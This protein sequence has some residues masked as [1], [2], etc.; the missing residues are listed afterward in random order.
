MKALKGGRSGTGMPEWEWVEVEVLEVCC[1][2]AGGL[3]E[4]EERPAKEKESEKR[5]KPETSIG[6][7]PMGGLNKKSERRRTK[8]KRKK[9]ARIITKWTLARH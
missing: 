1:A 5:E 4:A 8:K 6:T 7:T 9:R 3:E 2:G